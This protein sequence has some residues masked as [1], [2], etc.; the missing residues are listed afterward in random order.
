[1]TLKIDKKITAYSVVKPEDKASVDAS[2]PAPA[3]EKS[4]AASVQEKKATEMN[5]KIAR[6]L[7]LVGRTYKID[8]S[9]SNEHALY[10]TINDIILDEGTSFERRQPFEVFINSK[11]MDQ[12]Q[13]IVALTRIMLDLRV[14]ERTAELAAS[15]A[16]LP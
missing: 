2:A 8:K 5:E 15:N 1:M 12:F 7:M 9:P 6:P 4:P 11:N 14:T 3:V 13:W 10:V 16:S